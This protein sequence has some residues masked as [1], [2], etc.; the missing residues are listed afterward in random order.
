ML[1]LERGNA[2]LGVRVEIVF[3]EPMSLLVGNADVSVTEP[4]T[5][6]SCHRCGAIVVNADDHADFHYAIAARLG[7]GPPPGFAVGGRTQ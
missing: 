1:R 3:S 4:M 7:D 6:R 2:A 5:V